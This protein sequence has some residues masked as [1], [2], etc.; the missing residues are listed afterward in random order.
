MVF[1]YDGI[2]SHVPGYEAWRYSFFIPAALYPLLAVCALLFTLD[3]PD[4]DFR[5]LKAK[6][7]MAKHT[8]WKMVTAALFNYR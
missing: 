8:S 4:G 3:C 7:T 2:S 5:V 1:I 6:G